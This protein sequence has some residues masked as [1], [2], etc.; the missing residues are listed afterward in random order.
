VV[1]RGAVRLIECMFS[2]INK[3]TGGS[4]TFGNVNDG[5]VIMQD[6]V[7]DGN[8]TLIHNSPDTVVV[9]DNGNRNSYQTPVVET[10]S[11]ATGD[12][13]FES[14][15]ANQRVVINRPINVWLRQINRER[16]AGS[17]AGGATVRVFGDNVE[18]SDTDIE[19]DYTISDSTF[20]LVGATFDALGF[21]NAYP[22][23]G[24]AAFTITNSNASITTGSYLRS[25]SSVGHWLRDTEGGSTVGDI[26]NANVYQATTGSNRRV[27]IPKYVSP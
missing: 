11:S 16:A 9:R 19:A 8:L 15:G 23:A 12:L 2:I 3:G 7:P 1:V 14:A 27:V 21:P 4:W 10:G 20:E 13:F 6:F 5:E 26:T 24:K 17:V 18:L 25:G 22:T